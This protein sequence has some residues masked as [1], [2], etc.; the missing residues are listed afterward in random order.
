MGWVSV[1]HVD[2]TCPV[3]VVEIRLTSHINSK[4]KRRTT[5]TINFCTKG[6]LKFWIETITPIFI[7]QPLRRASP[8][9]LRGWQKRF[10]LVEIEKLNTL[11]WRVMHKELRVKYFASYKIVERFKKE[12]TFTCRGL[13]GSVQHVLGFS[14]RTSFE[15]RKKVFL[16]FSF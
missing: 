1:K 12:K 6:N 7:L 8:S 5:F 16:S 13:F 9:Q 15:I 10:N 4:L 3:Q 14:G 11:Q 2:G